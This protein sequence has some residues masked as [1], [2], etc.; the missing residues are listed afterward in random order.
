MAVCLLQELA[1]WEVSVDVAQSGALVEECGGVS[2]GTGTPGCSPLACACVAQGGHLTQDPTVRAY[3]H[4]FVPSGLHIQS[5][6]LITIMST[7]YG[8]PLGRIPFVYCLVLSSDSGEGRGLLIF[9]GEEPKAQRE[10]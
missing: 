4:S 10:S 9:L 8:Q 6:I 5:L 7:Y 1:G 3:L 2:R